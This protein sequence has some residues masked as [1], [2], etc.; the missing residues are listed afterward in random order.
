M[1][2]SNYVDDCLELF[3]AD[4]QE[5]FEVFMTMNEAWV[6]HYTPESKQQPTQCHGETFH[7]KI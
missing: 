5:F 6:Q 7:C 3:E 2:L 1:V 4:P